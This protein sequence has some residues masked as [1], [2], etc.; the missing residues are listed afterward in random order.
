MK[1]IKNIKSNALEGFHI[2]IEIYRL[3]FHSK[4]ANER[5][6]PRRKIIMKIVLSVIYFFWDTLLVVPRW[7]IS[8]MI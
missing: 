5:E 3:F 6:I 4:E 1:T 7:D 8:G 2:S